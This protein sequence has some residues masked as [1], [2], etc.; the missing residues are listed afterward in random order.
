MIKSFLNLGPTTYK[1]RT[2][3]KKERGSEAVT[4]TPPRHC[5][6]GYEQPTEGPSMIGILKPN[7]S[8]S[9]K[10]PSHP[11]SGRR[12]TWTRVTPTRALAWGSVTIQRLAPAGPPPLD[13]V[14]GHCISVSLNQI[15]G[16]EQR[17]RY[18]RCFTRPLQ[19]Q[20]PDPGGR[21][22]KGLMLILHHLKPL[23]GLR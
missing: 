17:H 1:K 16:R 19:Y 4:T 6:E 11:S 2:K 12:Y 22:L 5:R 14:G 18:G 10:P 8:G 3:Q 15:C 21:I 9:K 20:V 13:L 23:G 7:G